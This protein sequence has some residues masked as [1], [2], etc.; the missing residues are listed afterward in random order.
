MV[1]LIDVG[2]SISQCPIGQRRA[3]LL[4]YN[5]DIF[6]IDGVNTTQTNVFGPIQ[7]VCI[8]EIKKIGK[9]VRAFGK[10]VIH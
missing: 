3:Q 1:V 9:S 2:G 7:R 6:H 10:S 8:W 4:K 5:S